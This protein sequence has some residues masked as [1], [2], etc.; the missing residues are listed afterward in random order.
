MM[1]VFLL[2]FLPVILGGSAVFFL[3]RGNRRFLKLVLAFSG[4]YLL[5]LSVTHLIPE[6][7]RDAGKDIGLFVLAGFFFQILLE[8]FSEGIEHGHIHIHAGKHGHSHFK[9]PLAVM[10][11]LC[12]HSF[13]EGMPLARPDKDITQPLLMGIVLHNI[14]VSFALMSMLTESGTSRRVSVILMVLFA[15]MSPLGVVFSSVLYDHA[16]AMEINLYF[17][18]IMALVI[19]IFLHISTTILFESSEDHR[20]NLYKFLVILAGAGVAIAI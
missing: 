20:F 11:G 12:I 2:L 7:Y 9:F 3:K 16:P 10:A 4:S 14:P 19:G 15:L 5:A 1:K 18:R 17:N 6:I 8:F 13:M